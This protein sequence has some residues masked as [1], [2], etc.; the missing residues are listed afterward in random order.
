MRL[1]TNS[2]HKPDEDEVQESI[3]VAVR[4]F[5]RGATPRHLSTSATTPNGDAA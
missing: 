3:A 1:L 4:G 2:P 5:L